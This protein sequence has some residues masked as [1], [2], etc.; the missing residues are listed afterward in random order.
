VSNIATT[1]YYHAI[2]TNG[3][4]KDT[5]LNA[6][7]KYGVGLDA[8]TINGAATVCSGTNSTTL[9]LTAYTGS[10]QWQSSTDNVT[11]TN[12]TGATSSNYTAVNLTVTKYYRVIVSSASC[13]TP[14]TG[15]AVAITVNSTGVNAGTI[16]GA[17]TVCSGTNSSVLT[18]TGSQGNIQWQSSSDNITFTDIVGENLSTYTA[19]NLTASRYYRI[20]VT[21]GTCGSATS[22]SALITVAQLPVAGTISGPTSV[23]SGTNSAALTLTGYTGTI[24]W[25]SSTDNVTFSNI[26]GATGATYTA[27]N[28]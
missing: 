26:S 3:N 25:Q 8:G 12:I 11:F 14:V 27:T 13:G 2:L 22:S 6:V 4:C 28:L 9:T 23:C 15:T 1:T 21:N 7:I 10:I 24:Q 16:S 17:A 20:V 5:S 19:T 18:I